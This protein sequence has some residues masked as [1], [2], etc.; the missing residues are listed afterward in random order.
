MW[1]DILNCKKLQEE[2]SPGPKKTCS[3]SNIGLLHIFS[4]PAV[5]VVVE[6]IMNDQGAEDRL[7]EEEPGR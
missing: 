4:D 6:V 7:P 2:T 1:A 5:L 3:S